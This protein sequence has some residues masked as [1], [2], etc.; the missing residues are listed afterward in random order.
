MKKIFLILLFILVSL[1]LFCEIS[2]IENIYPRTV[3]CRENTPYVYMS[4]IIK[5]GIG[6]ESEYNMGMGTFISKL[7]L[8]QTRNSSQEEVERVFYSTG[9]SLSLSVNLDYIEIKA[10]TLKEDFLEALI[11]IAECLTEPKVTNENIEKAKAETM[12]KMTEEYDSPF[13]K[14]YDMLR[15]NIYKGNPYKRSLYGNIQSVQYI[16]RN[17]INQYYRENFSL[18]DIIVTV[19]GDLDKEYAED[20]IKRTFVQG[21]KNNKRIPFDFEDQLKENRTCRT[22]NS[23]ANDKLTYYYCGYLFPGTQS[24]DYYPCLV[25]SAILGEGKSSFV[26]RDIR[27]KLGIGYMIGFKY[28]T[29]RRQSHAY[30]YLSALDGKGKTKRAKEAFLSIA[31]KIKTDGVLPED[32]E[33]A[34]IYLT[35]QNNIRNLDLMEK[36]HNICLKEA[37]F[38]DYR[39]FEKFDEKI[40]MVSVNDI[41]KAAEKYMKNY[42]EIISFPKGKNNDTEI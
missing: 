4:M 33:R 36:T 15:Q 22:E 2:K 11:I 27:Q 14:M 24:P 18:S 41:K 1:P 23:D 25:L 9:C 32:L 28:E 13:I 7:L 34:K 3:I 40:N 37:I 5:T 6:S 8:I 12:D 19:T 21:F 16:N 29:L 42:C 35:E 39:E 30:F 17:M 31:E 26:F 20:C 38:G 10:I